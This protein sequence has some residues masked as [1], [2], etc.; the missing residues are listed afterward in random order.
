[1]RIKRL[2]VAVG[3]TGRSAR[4]IAA[5]IRDAIEHGRLKPGAAL[6]S[7]R[8][9]ARQLGVARN[10][11][12]GAMALLAD[13][14]LVEV[15][16]GG[17]SFVAASALPAKAEAARPAHRFALTAWARA[18]PPGAAP[19]VAEGVRFDFR[20]GL[21]DLKTIPFDEW[22]RSGNRML[23]TLGDALGRYGDPSGDA[24]LRREIALY[25]ARSRGVACDAADIVVTAGAQQAFDLIARVLVPAR[26]RVAFEA[27]GYPPAAQVFAAAGAAVSGVPV[28]R[29][30]LDP[31][32]IP[33]GSLMAYVTPSHQFP[34]GVTMPEPRRTALLAWADRTGAFIVEDDYDSEYVHGA[35][36]LPAL[37]A[38][39]A[40][41]RVLYVGTF[42]K[43]LMP[44]IRLG[45]VVVPGSL[46][47]T[48]AA[49]K[50]LADRHS[51]SLAQAVLA[52]FMASGAFGRHVARMRAIYADRHA[53]IERYRDAL[54][55][56]GHALLPSGAG[57][58]ACVLLG[59]GVDEA[60]A[61]EA[62]RR[63]QIGLYGLGALARG[64]APL[65]GLVLGFG[66]LDAAGV[67]AGMKRL[68]A[69]L[70]GLPARP[71]R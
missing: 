16:P 67:E 25:V 35:S 26:S 57:L 31:A 18:L 53:R 46:R 19:A 42:S 23:R 48:F 69:A 40:S 70:E 3:A 37:R 55:A 52:E 11:V 56:L 38:R 4:G 30:G 54:A 50:G 47:R 71:I 66:N 9:L 29:D 59:R 10:T 32:R 44:G 15:R 62:G 8:D 34:L 28:D 68:L 13:N 33:A 39:D 7:T 61:I 22:R 6:P 12:L 5:A 63:R 17:G 51:N 45:F 41:G 14:A 60:G 21:P 1:M 49:A 58:H 64:A 36:P 24:V 65:Q 27:P 2:P 20:P 43:T